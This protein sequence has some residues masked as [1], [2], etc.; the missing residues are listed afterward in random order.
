MSPRLNF[1]RRAT[2]HGA[3][4]ALATSGALAAVALGAQV[5]TGASGASAAQVCG[6]TE[7]SPYDGKWN[8][9]GAGNPEDPANGWSRGVTQLDYYGNQIGPYADFAN[10]YDNAIDQTISHPV[11]GLSDTNRTITFR[12][13]WRNATYGGVASTNTQ[14]SRLNIEYNGVRYAQIETAGPNN[15]HQKATV[16]P[17]NGASI[18]PAS[19]ADRSIG[20]NQMQ[21]Y[22][23]TLT[24]PVGVPSDAVLALKMS[25]T[26]A[27]NTP[28]VA[29]DPSTKYPS[30]YASDDFWVD[31]VS[32]YECEEETAVP[33]GDPWVA[34]GA[35]ALTATALGVWVVRRRRDEAQALAA[36]RVSG[37]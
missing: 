31:A 10:Y 12:V 23:V 16:T 25:V 11:T 5:V 33:L 29:P 18:V 8:L 20:L 36:G 1:A 19:W 17:M 4:A 28:G 35:A 37:F 30:Y 22:D 13:F 3:L 34:T 14:S 26:S 2:A 7:Y 27:N 21:W 6:Y 9:S 32:A 15:G 24:L